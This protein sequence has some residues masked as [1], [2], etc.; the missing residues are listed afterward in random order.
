MH[1]CICIIKRTYFCPKKVRHRL[2]DR[3][4]KRAGR[5]AN[6]SWADMLAVTD[7]MCRDHLRRTKGKVAKGHMGEPNLKAI[8]N[9]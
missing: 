8:A 5:V 1:V 4:T 9:V 6:S 2:A 7:K 3:L